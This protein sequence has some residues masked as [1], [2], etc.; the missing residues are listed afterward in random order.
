MCF[1]VAWV[2][3]W[4]HP[5]PLN[6]LMTHP[7]QTNHCPGTLLL[8]EDVRSCW[9][10]FLSFC[11]F[12]FVSAFLPTP[13]PPITLVVYYLCIKAICFYMLLIDSWP[14]YDAYVYFVR[15]IIHSSFRSTLY[16]NQQFS[17][18][19]VPYS[20]ILYV[21]KK[22]FTPVILREKTH[23]LRYRKMNDEEAL[24]FEWVGK[25]LL[26]V[27]KMATAYVL[28]SGKRI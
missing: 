1:W 19:L 15:W 16:I 20:G 12:V 9:I 25:I 21:N 2:H 13:L 7:G 28:H 22:D 11:L 4:S 27:V 10:F 3:S 5:N 24:L 18:K 8:S 17:I 6:F 26:Q 23:S 14:C